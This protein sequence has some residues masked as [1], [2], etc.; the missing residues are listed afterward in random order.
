MTEEGDCFQVNFN[1][2]FMIDGLEGVQPAGKYSVEIYDT[3][4]GIFWFLKPRSRYAWFRI[5]E[6]PGLSGTL[7]TVRIDY[8]DLMKA[9][10]R[11]DRLTIEAERNQ[12]D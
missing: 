6:S 3:R 12:V 1:W 7:R 2:P 5:C 8:D 4:Q 11:D 9:I 10:S